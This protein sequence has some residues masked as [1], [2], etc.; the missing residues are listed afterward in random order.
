[1]HI[2]VGLGDGA[3]NACGRPAARAASG[4]SA[5]IEPCRAR[6]LEPPDMAGPEVAPALA[7][8]LRELEANLHPA[9]SRDA[10]DCLNVIK[11][12]GFRCSRK[13]HSMDLH[14]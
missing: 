1:M 13:A 11:V 9:V 7:A 6:L 3:G 4:A 14:A 10:H 12:V 5:D 2:E 8:S